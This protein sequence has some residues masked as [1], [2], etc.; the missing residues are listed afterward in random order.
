MSSQDS[1]WCQPRHFKYIYQVVSYFVKIDDKW[2][3][4]GTKHGKGEKL[5]GQ[6]YQDGGDKRARLKNKRGSKLEKTHK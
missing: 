3:E 1:K 4:I 6:R 2:G 5:A